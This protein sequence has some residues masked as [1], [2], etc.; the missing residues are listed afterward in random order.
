[1]RWLNRL[2]SLPLRGKV[3]LTVLGAGV[4]ALGAS[5]YLSFGYWRS[6]ARI[7]AEQQA[8]LAATSTR[9][10]LEAALRLDRHDPARRTLALLREEGPVTSARLYRPDGTILFS[11][12][13][14]EEG[15][16]AA[17]IWIPDPM[18][19]PRDG[20][21]RESED[22]RSVRAY[23]PLSAP[24]PA[25]LE[26]ELSVAAI[27]AA[28][29]R[30][31]RLGIG[32]MAVSLLAVA[33]IVVTM[34]EREVVAPLHR[35]DV[36]LGTDGQPAGHGRGGEIGELERSVSRLIEKEREVQ[37]R[38]ADQA[39]LAQVGELAAEMAHEFK[40]PLASVR[41]AVDMLLDEYSLDDTGRATLEAVDVQL[42]RLHE[43]MRDLFSLAK[44]IGTEAAPVD[45][46]DAL[47]EALLELGTASRGGAVEVRRV[48]P[49]ERVVVPGD[50]RR[51]R[52]AF[53]NVLSNAVEAMPEGGVL[54][55]RVQ[56][57]AGDCVEI[58]FGDTGHG[59][60]PEQ[61]QRMLKPFYSTKP[62]GTG[63]GLPLVARVVSAHRGGL[64]IESAPG[65][66]TT[67]RITLPAR[68]PTRAGG[69]S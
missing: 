26:V 5:T 22:R 68:V 62:L 2:S 42:E 12:D 29:D 61:V 33:V 3:L 19:L 64:S 40:R 59:V 58:A 7:A 39:G 30:G 1:M 20:I 25:V 8:L 15:R 17:A 43:T 23:S 27:S 16:R 52:Q 28:M 46:G 57:S 11:S 9:L 35:M 56:P 55:V 69:C 32:L 44:P 47:D 63:L 51:L 6:E 10:T 4:A 24:E 38:A 48:Y 50:P 21:A 45:L 41:T 13:P 36:L 66:G 31:A 60:D 49:H 53:L 14:S 65:R 18:Q 37:A 54:T 67:V 34:F